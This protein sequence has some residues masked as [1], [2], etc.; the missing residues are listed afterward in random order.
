LSVY[1]DASAILPW[2]LDE[3]ASDLILR[4]LASQPERLV[5]DFAAAEVAA[6]LSRLVRTRTLDASGANM[7]LA[8]FDAWRADT[9]ETIEL[10]AGDARLAGTY[11]RRFELML[12]AP[13]ALHLALARRVDATLV[14]LDRRMARAAAELDVPVAI[15][16]P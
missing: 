10:R 5:S 1:L 13:D 11:V 6:V 3:P 7:R 16:M 8:D 9:S 12:R 4:F 15:P 14:T 2:L